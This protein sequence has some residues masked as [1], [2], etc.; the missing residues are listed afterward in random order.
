M[1]ILKG[2]ITSLRWLAIKGLLFTIGAGLAATLVITL[3]A[4]PSKSPADTWRVA[5]AHFVGVWCACRAY[6][7][8]F[9]V[10][11]RYAGG[12]PYAGLLAALRASWSMMFKGRSKP[13]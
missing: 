13:E 2:D 7:F 11:E 10:I 6:Y 4:Q 9:Y 5:A 12:G 8:A 3:A 1:D